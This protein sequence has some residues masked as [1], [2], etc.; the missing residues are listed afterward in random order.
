M[1]VLSPERLSRHLREGGTGGV[2]LLEGEEEHLRDGAV[3]EVVAAHLDPA[4]RDFNLD[5][6]RGA[7]VTP[8]T[9][10]SLIQT[11]PMMAEWRVVVVREAQALAVSSTL[12]SLLESVVAAPPPGLALVLAADLGTSRAKIWDALRKKAVTVKFPRL[13]DADLPGWL[14]GW[15]T[16]QGLELAPDAARAIAS[17]IGPDLATSV[18]ELEKLRDY[19]GER[20]RITRDDVVAVVGALPR[21]DRWEWMSLVADRQFDRARA[22]IPV[23]LDAGENGVGLVIGL[24]P[25]FLRMGV[26]KAQGRA[27]LEAILPQNQKWLARQAEAQARRWSAEGIGRALDDLRRADRLLKSAPMSDHQV[28]EELILRL[29]HLRA[30]AA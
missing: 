29:Q 22:A 14:M 12:R 9:L 13:T 25:Q 8:E 16:D 10:G 21:Q 7:E 23:L 6:V 28:L 4:T 11:P 1:P 2:F 18:R 19:V 17:A 3:R 20:K 26:C 24:A 5:E 27:G 30:E 15:A